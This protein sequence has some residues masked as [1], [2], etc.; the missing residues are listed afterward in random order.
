M[1]VRKI[2]QGLSAD[3]LI[4]LKYF[5]FEADIFQFLVIKFTV[6]DIA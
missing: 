1:N 6:G 3:Q 5:A 4:N 2:C